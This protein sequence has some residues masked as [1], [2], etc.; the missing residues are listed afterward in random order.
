[1]AGDQVQGLLQAQ[2]MFLRK[3]ANL[4]ILISSHATAI[5]L[6][7]LGLIIGHEDILLFSGRV[8]PRSLCAFHFV[9]LAVGDLLPRF[10][11]AFVS[12]SELSSCRPLRSGQ[13]ISASPSSLFRAG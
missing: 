8:N 5:R 6:A 7:N 11:L 12:S 13:V 9:P 3:F 2:A 1:M 10:G 4:I